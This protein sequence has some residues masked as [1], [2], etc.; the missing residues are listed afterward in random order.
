VIAAVKR[1]AN[2]PV[3]VAPTSGGSLPL[4]LIEEHLNAKVMTLCIVN[5]DNNQHSENENVRIQNLW[6]SLEQL[7]AIMNMK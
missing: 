6:D 2:G 1:A 5:H 3:V 7:A 4:Y